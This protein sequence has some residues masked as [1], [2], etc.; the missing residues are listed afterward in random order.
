MNGWLLASWALSSL[1]VISGFVCVSIG[2]NIDNHGI[3]QESLYLMAIPIFL[4][5]LGI[6]LGAISLFLSL[7]NF[8]QKHL[9]QKNSH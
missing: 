7:L 9:S 3:V 1:G 4:I 6:I 8:Y 2:S 5:G